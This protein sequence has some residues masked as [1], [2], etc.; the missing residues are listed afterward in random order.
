MKY[1]VRNSDNEV[2]FESDNY[3]EAYDKCCNDT[4]LYEKC[5]IC[6]EY[7]PYDDMSEFDGQTYCEYCRDCN[8][9]WCERCENYEYNDRCSKVNISGGAYQWWCEHCVENHAFWCDHCE[10]YYDDDYYASYEHNGEIFCEY[11]RDECLCWCDHCERYYYDTEGSYDGD[12]DEWLCYDCQEELSNQPTDRVRGYHCRPKMRYYKNSE[13]YTEDGTNFKGFGIELEIDRND[14]SYAENRAVAH[15]NN[16]IGG[17]AYYNRDGSLNYGFEIITQPH[18][19]EAL[20][21]LNWQ[22]VLKGLVRLG[23]RSHDLKTCGLHMHVSRELFGEN[24]EERTEN[25]AKTIYFYEAFWSDILKFSRRT[26]EQADRWASRY[27]G[28]KPTI[29]DTRK[30]AKGYY[31]RYYAVNLTN[32]KT[33]EFRLMRG[34]LNYKT[35]MATLDF[36][37]TIAENSKKV[38]EIDNLS[39]WLDGIKPETKLYMASRNCFGYTN[40]NNETEEQGD[41]E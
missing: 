21:E 5:D 8:L 12:R 16:L 33:I 18:T 4:T 3:S 7:E 27:C 28:A 31:G 40:P 19:R 20:T 32:S 11:C 25:I 10:E 41:E 2:I 24:E 17:H 38:T 35:F 30:V 13:E 34:T 26:A 29:D 14:H 23:Y 39:Q 37:M 6:G 36:L 9:T 15:I 1:Q 22:E